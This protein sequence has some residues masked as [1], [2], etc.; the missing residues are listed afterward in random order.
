MGS[1]PIPYTRKGIRSSDT[2]NSSLVNELTHTY[3]SVIEN[4]LTHSVKINLVAIETVTTS[5]LPNL[6]PFRC[7]LSLGVDV[8]NRF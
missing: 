3:S 1:V 4:Y 7:V 6:A 8:S 5:K 2:F